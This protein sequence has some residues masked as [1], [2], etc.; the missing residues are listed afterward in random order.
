MKSKKQLRE[1]LSNLISKEIRVILKE[2]KI[3]PYQIDDAR[4]K[5]LYDKYEKG[6]RVLKRNREYEKE[7]KLDVFLRAA[8]MTLKELEELDRNYTDESWSIFIDTKKNLV[9]VTTD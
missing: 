9:Q 8:H 2:E 3:Y 7:A 5:K 6:E 4:G 1:K